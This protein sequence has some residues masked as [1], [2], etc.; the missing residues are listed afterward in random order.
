[1]GAHCFESARAS[2]WMRP[3]CLGTSEAAMGAAGQRSRGAWSMASPHHLSSSCMSYWWAMGKIRKAA[4]SLSSEG[5]APSP[6][7]AAG[8]GGHAALRTLKAVISV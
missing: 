2:H 4:S 3:G 8:N 1:M 6:R 7:S 5:G